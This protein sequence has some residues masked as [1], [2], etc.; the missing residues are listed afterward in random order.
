MTKYSWVSRK[1]ESRQMKG[2]HPVWRGIGFIFMI[3]TPIVGF[4]LTSLI[5]AQNAIEGWFLIPRDLVAPGR[6]PYLYLKIGGTV[7]IVFVVYILFLF[8]TFLTY[9]IFGPKRLGPQDAPQTGYSG[10]PSRR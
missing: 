5:L 4:F 10:K 7:V 2:I 9:R 1:S 8:V 3:V 6:D